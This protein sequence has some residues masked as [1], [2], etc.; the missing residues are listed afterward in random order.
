MTP[1]SST[2]NVS[3]LNSPAAAEPCRPT[4]VLTRR[5]ALSK[6]ECVTTAT[7]A[8][9]SSAAYVAAGLPYLS[10]GVVGDLTGFAILATAGAAKG[11]RLQHEAAICLVLIGGV[12]VLDPE[13]PLRVREPY[14]WALFSTGLTT[15]VL[16]RRRLC[17]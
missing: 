10:R 2:S 6:A 17:D 7:A 14:W 13:W 1:G 12:L 3:D 4:G 5:F 8:V 11:A 9:V 16:L 15:Y